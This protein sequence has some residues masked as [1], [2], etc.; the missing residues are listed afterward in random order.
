MQLKKISQIEKFLEA[1]NGCK[2]DVILKS[3]YGDTYNLKSQLSQY[4]GIGALLGERG[5]ELELW[6][7]L[8]D[9]EYIFLKLF[10]E[11]PDMI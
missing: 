3:P 7:Q 8:K 11:N 9:D 1:V 2:G 6:C 10:N 4:V 5:D